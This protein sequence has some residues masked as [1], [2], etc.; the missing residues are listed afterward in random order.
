M[1]VGFVFSFLSIAV[2]Q[3]AGAQDLAQLTERFIGMTAVSGFE[4]AMADS[5]IQLL[6]A[7]QRDRAGNVVLTYGD[8]DPVRAVVCP[9]DEW[10]YV[11]GGVHNHGYV[12]VR[13]VGR[14]SPPFFDQSHAARRMTI[15]GRNGPVAAVVGVAS[16][17]LRRARESQTER[18]FGA[19]DMYLDLGTGSP[20]D[21]A[22]LG[23]EMLNPVAMEKAPHLY[24][25]SLISGPEAGQRS[26]CAALVAAN[27]DGLRPVGTVVIAFTV[28]S[29][30]GHRGLSTLANGYGPFDRTLLIDYPLTRRPPEGLGN[31][32]R[33]RVPTK[34]DGWQIETIDLNDVSAA[35]TKIRRW[36]EGTQ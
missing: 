15:W 2:F 1:R 36:M 17:H 24:G 14:G 31:V 13:R 16:I 27:T 26:A 32:E 20:N 12:T 11:V 19:D 5:L 21:V 9:M 30:I 7:A 35:V 6:P 29:R 25:S 28:E 22:N 10:G 4:Q 18:L 8:G 3:G 23:V 34:Y 33:L